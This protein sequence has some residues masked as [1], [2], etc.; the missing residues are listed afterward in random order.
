MQTSNQ[1][2][3]PL[4][5]KLGFQTHDKVVNISS[6]ADR[7]NLLI[8]DVLPITA[9]ENV[10]TD[11]ALVEGRLL[12]NE[13]EVATVLVELECRDLPPVNKDS[14]GQWVVEPLNQT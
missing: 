9:H 13:R 5:E 7:Y 11:G 4:K 10:L 6:L 14:S 2:C 12:T 1:L 3:R 8:R